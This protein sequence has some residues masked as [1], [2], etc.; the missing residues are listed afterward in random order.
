MGSLLI[1]RVAEVGA[2]NRAS[3]LRTVSLQ[4]IAGLGALATVYSVV[5]LVFGSDLLVLVYN[6]PEITAASGLLWL[7]SVCAIVDAVTAAMAF[8]LVAIA[9]TKCTFW[10]RVASTAVLLT[11]ALCLGPAIGLDAIVWAGTAGSAASACIHGVALITSIRRQSYRRMQG[12]FVGT[13]VGGA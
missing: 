3:R 6:K 8:V 12:M 4:T 13:A 9:V 1:P 7:F 10:A 2:S 11:G 5:I